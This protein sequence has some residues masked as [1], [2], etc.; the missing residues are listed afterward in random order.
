MKPSGTIEIDKKEYE[1]TNNN[2]NMKYNNK[3]IIM[4]GSLGAGK[5]TAAKYITQKYNFQHLSFVEEIWKPILHNRNLEVNRE[6][7]QKLGI[8]LMKEKGPYKI[9][10]ELLEKAIYSQTILIDDVRRKDVVEIIKQLCDQVF[11]VYID[12]DFE[13]RYPRLIQRDN[14]QSEYEQRKAEKVET[15]LSIPELKTIADYYINNNDTID[16]FYLNIDSAVKKH[17]ETLC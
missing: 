11:L 1:L 10:E 5:T 2:I 15:E 4:A 13:T 6:N 16:L 9:V 14:V 17:R 3:I 8:E 12:A 7:L